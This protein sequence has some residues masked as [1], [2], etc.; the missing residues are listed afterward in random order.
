MERRERRQ[1]EPGEFQDPLSNYDPKEYEDQLEHALLS[2]T[3]ESIPFDDHLKA[4]ADMT[5][6]EAIQLMNDN[7]FACV[8]LMDEQRTPIGIFS[9]RD[10]LVRV[11]DRYEDVKDLPVSDIMTAQPLTA[12]NTDSL[13]HVLNVMVSGGFRHVPVVDQDNKLQGMVG[14]RKV[15]AFLQQYFPRDYNI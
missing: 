7:N 8:V 3:V 10:V 15:T 11:S 9:E 5:V 2:D 1:P 13:A 14:V 12:Y 6:A 4:R